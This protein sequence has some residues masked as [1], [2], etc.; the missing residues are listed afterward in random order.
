MASLSEALNFALQQHQ[1]GRL[2]EAEQI[3]QQILA[4]A[5]SC[6]EAL[7]LLGIVRLQHRDFP[8]AIEQIERAIRID[9]GQAVFF[10]NLGEAYRHLGRNPEAIACYRR[11]LELQPQSADA[12][13]N[14]GLALLASG[15][16]DEAVA[17]CRRAVELKPVYP[18]A[19]NNLGNALKASG[20]IVEAITCYRQ[21]LAQRPAFA[22]AL[23]NLG[24]A[25][26][27][28]GQSSEA[29]TCYER[30]L[31]LEPNLLETHN[32][33]GLACK[34]LGQVDAALRSF[35]RALD[36]EP[37][38]VEALN[39]LGI[40]LQEQGQLAE[41]V[42][43]YRRALQLRPALVEVHCNLGDA[44]QSQGTYQ[45]AVASYRRALELRPTL[46][47]AHIK[48]GNALKVLGRVEEALACQHEAV[49][50]DPG[51]YTAHHNLGIVL[52]IHGQ[53]NQAMAAYERALSL[54]PDCVESL[55][56]LAGL[57]RLKGKLSKAV[58]LCEQ[59]LWHQPDCAEAYGTMTAALQAQGRLDEALASSRRATELK[60]ESAGLYGIYLA[61]LQYSPDVTL[62]RL[63]EAHRE[64]DTRYAAPLRRAWPAQ[65]KARAAD[66]ALRLG[67]VSP[68]FARH[69]VGTFLI[70]GL[71]NLDPRQ[72]S[73]T[74]YSDTIPPDDLTARFQMA[75]SRWRDVV[76]RTDED[77]ARL[78]REDEIDIL[79]DLAGHTAGNRLLVFARK[80]APLQITWLDYEGTTGLQAVDYLLA[81]RYEVPPE[82][83]GWYTEKVLRMPDGFV[84][85][86]PPAMAPPVSPLPALT[87]GR[88]TFGSFNLLGK[89]TPRV[90][91]TWAR[92]LHR[93]PGSRLFLKYHGLDD[94]GT[95]ARFRERL[96]AEG[97]S[98]ERLILEG[99]SPYAEFLARYHQL[100]I[101]LDP[102][103][104]TGGLT[105]CEAL[106]MG[107]PVVT[108]PGET[109]AGRHGLSHLSNAGLTELIAR[110]LDRYV[111]L[112]V[113]LAEDL[114][115]LVEM[116]RRLRTQVAD[117]PLCDGKRFADNLLAL[118][119]RVWDDRSGS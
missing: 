39:N 66:Q 81:D 13:N 111:E 20:R 1:A 12:F 54:K 49:R 113:S 21:A 108:C 5:P 34:A 47:S 17:S 57:I 70:A 16:T 67:F 75:S 74:C 51:N 43:C 44:L 77:M 92:I 53:E 83:E 26:Q 65:G 80:P 50:L 103:P 79:F 14:M 104:Y 72:C 94:P 97:I 84:C 114:P 28:Q 30:A 15:Q 99:P 46:A 110:D 55:V 2:G 62:A 22:G 98:A 89:I 73:V 11:A 58:A 38:Y 117:S 23:N 35:R 33:L 105:T 61:T 68:H 93:V 9:P 115:R 69:P 8:G 96:A 19:H 119:R 56:N 71:E 100:D 41:A 6:A 63:L 24:L 32:N 90:I 95:G 101:A 36:L 76:G 18:E 82:A 118:L 40:A 37:D 106:W 116:R 29:M 3:Y 87:T 107:V 42:A 31:Q 91:A 4:A 60:P 109:F 86:E 59:A 25:L 102:F 10:S 45:E 88:V 52:Q 85:Y 27:E 112:A 48:L 78:I 64:Y 7:H